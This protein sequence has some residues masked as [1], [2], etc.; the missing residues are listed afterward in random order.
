LAPDWSRIALEGAGVD[1]MGSALL[2]V[3][4]AAR[5]RRE[6]GSAHKSVLVLT[7]PY[8]VLPCCRIKFI[9]H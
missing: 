8:H 2:Q 6:A 7:G 4:L 5:E 9:I 1:R 3:A